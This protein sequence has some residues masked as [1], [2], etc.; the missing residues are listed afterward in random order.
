MS[1]GVKNCLDMC[2]VMMYEI[3]LRWALNSGK[4]IKQL[5]IM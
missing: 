1:R 5:G 3:R 2:T 4:A